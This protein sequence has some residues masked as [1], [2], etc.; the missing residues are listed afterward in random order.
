MNSAK[1]DLLHPNEAK[2]NPIRPMTNGEVDSDSRSRMSA[3]SGPADEAE[4]YSLQRMLQDST[5]R[6]LYVGDSATLSY[7]QLIRMLVESIA[8]KSRF[9]MD[10]KR[11]MIMEARISLPPS[12]MPLGVLPG[13]R[14]ADVLV[15][16][17]FINA[18]LA[19]QSKLDQ[20]LIISIDSWL[21]RAVL[22]QL[23]LVFAIGLVLSKP[24]PGSEE[25]A[26]IKKLRESKDINRAEVFFRNAKGLA[27]PVSGFEDADFWSVQA[28]LLMALYML[29]SPTV[30]AF[31]YGLLGMAVRS[32]F[33]LGLHRE[34]DSFIFNPTQCKV[35]RNLWRTL[36]V[37]DR[38]LAA[39]L[40]RPTAISD[41][42]CSDHA[43]DAPEKSFE[44]EADQVNSAALDAAVRTCRVIG[45]TLREV[46]S[47]RKIS[48]SVA[49]DIAEKF[50]NWNGLLHRALH[51]QRA[52]VR[53]ISP[54]HGIAV[55]HINLLHC[56]SITLLA[57]PFFLYILKAGVT[58]KPSR[59]SQ[60]MESFAQTCVEAAQHSLSIAQ[61]AMDGNYLPQCN[62]FV[63]YFVF[64]AGLIILSNEFA[65]LY[66]NP[67]ADSAIAS[68]I[69][70]LKYCAESDAQAQRVIYIVEAFHEANSHRPPSTRSISF[71]N[72]KVP[73]I[74]PASSNPQHDPM[75]HFFAYTK[76]S[77]EQRLPILA[78]NLKNE[79]SSISR[80]HTG[81]VQPLIPS[82]LQ[83][84]S[85]DATGTSPVGSQVAPS[86]VPGMDTM[87]G[88]EVGFDF[89]DLWPTW[90]PP[91]DAMPL[92]QHAEPAEA[93]NHY[94]LG[95]PPIALGNVLAANVNIPLYSP[96]DF[97]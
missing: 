90:H 66:H 88:T 80:T 59:L 39:S 14:T 70:I 20:R 23:N 68:C 40:G 82:V 44:N 94:T 1:A 84:P 19:K 2:S 69:A 83:Q 49:Q 16:S 3:T 42:D 47:K 46:Y 95:P 32:A 11:H 6:L 75:A 62:P 54:S 89:D 50:E 22:C 37:L 45:Q 76:H 12:N 43:L 91:T 63:I 60:R 31:A 72:R 48:T 25:E 15:E 17:Y 13:R 81:S 61:T 53:P 4:A 97:R 28:L 73:V 29:H 9:T 41:E 85:P 30:F 79:R 8:G 71:P 38:F 36:Y 86:G 27:D 96:S 87:H 93:F 35:R 7:L 64:A 56:H 21:D 57:R 58:R 34:E 24:V 5:G 77:P 33:A 26:V 92:G 52:T 51:W 55:L 67:D 18:G 74:T 78:P 10:P 65:S